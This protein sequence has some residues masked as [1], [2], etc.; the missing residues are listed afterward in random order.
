MVRDQFGSDCLR[1]G[2]A[3]S[4]SGS[5]S[6][7]DWLLLV[8]CVFLVAVRPWLVGRW[9][10]LQVC[11]LSGSVV[12]RGIT[13]FFSKLIELPFRPDSQ[14]WR[15]R[16]RWDALCLRVRCCSCS[17]LCRVV[18]SLWVLG[19]CSVSA[20]SFVS[21]VRRILSWEGGG[22]KQGGV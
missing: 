5:F 13:P 17:V 7:P 15:G 1:S 12:V 10:K 2:V 19:S 11:L 9:Q 22:G 21:L 20:P 18:V 14:L 6:L 8:V 3:L 4:Y 16:L